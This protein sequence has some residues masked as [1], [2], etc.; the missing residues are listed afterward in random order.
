M[1]AMIRIHAA[2]I[3]A[4]LNFLK[5][6]PVRPVS[7][8]YDPPAG[9]P[10]RSGDYEAH[11]VLIRDARPY[12]S[13]LSLD[14]EGFALLQTPTRFASFSDPAA[15]RSVY[16]PEVERLIAEAAGAVPSGGRRA[17]HSRAGAEHAQRFHRPLGPRPRAH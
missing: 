17:G 13:G 2:A 5:P 10:R 9:V 14:R 12:A 1:T 8:Q 6:M 11:R 15:I 7:Y 16:Y 3:D 4:P